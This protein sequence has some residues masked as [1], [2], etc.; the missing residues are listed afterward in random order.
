MPITKNMGNVANT[1]MKPIK[2]RKN[3]EFTVTIDGLAIGGKGIAKLN[4]L[5]VFVDRG[6]PGQVA[7]I[8]VHRKKKNYV[9]AKVVEVL[10]ESVDETVPFCVHEPY[11]GG[12]QWQRLKYEKQLEWK[13]KHVK[14]ALSHIGGLKTVNIHAITPSPATKFYRNK[15]EFTFSSRRWYRPDEITDKKEVLSRECGLGL[16]VRGTYDKVFNIEECY[17]E[18]PEAVSIL[19]TVRNFC[20]QSGLPAYDI[21]KHTGFWRFLVVREGKRTGHR[22]VHLITAEHKAANLIVNELASAIENLGLATTFV[23]S[24]NNSK[25]QV[26]VGEKSRVYW[27]DGT[28]D[29]RL[30][31][32]TFTISA[33]SFFQTNPL[34]AE[35]LYDKITDC[36]TLTGKETVWDLYCGTGSIAL[37]VASRANRVI[38][39]ELVEEAV[40]DAYR[41]AEKNNITNC[42]FVVGD[43]KNLINN[44]TYQRPDVIITDPPRAGMHPKVL[45]ALLQIKPKLIIAVSCNPTTLARDLSTLAEEYAITD[46]FPFDLFPHTPHIECIAR[47]ELKRNHNN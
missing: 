42:S 11:C 44:T 28:I 10:S 46:I 32:L 21:K 24:I 29:E 31:S 7:K 25:A 40:V 17:L 12:C 3:D 30:G 26:A 2:I 23:H 15:M 1:N 41:N 14:D 18:S 39:F 34:G 9:E 16:H 47:L 13:S 33:H 4:G 20:I 38:G 8:R 43:I 37:Y 35:L 45:K 5:V 19:K 22:L 36:A 27:G 6:L